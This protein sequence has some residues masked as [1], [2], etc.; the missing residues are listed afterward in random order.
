VDFVV[1]QGESCT[2][3]DDDKCPAANPASAKCE[4][5]PPKEYEVRPSCTIKFPKC[6]GKC[7]AVI[8]GH[9]KCKEADAK[10]TIL[11]GSACTLEC[12]GSMKSAD[13][14][15]AT[16]ECSAALSGCEITP[17]EITCS[18][19]CFPASAMILQPNGIETSVASL[20]Q[21]DSVV[22]V[23]REW[24]LEDD[25]YLAEFHAGQPR[26]H[27]MHKF[28]EIRHLCQLGTPLRVTAGHLLY[29]TEAKQAHAQPELMPAGKLRPGIH[30]VLA[31]GCDKSQPRERLAP[32]LVLNVTTVWAE[33]LYNPLTASRTAIVDGVATSNLALTSES[34][35]AA[36]TAS[37]LVRRIYEP[38]AWLLVAPVH[39]CAMLGLSTSWL[40]NVY[41][42]EVVTS[43]LEKLG[44][45]VLYAS[46]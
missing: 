18:S 16:C 25:T 9:A 6:K 44:Q 32:S 40:S 19:S 2:W 17:M 30:A 34:I 41:L 12:S 21:G 8:P 14:K 15:T 20:K 7:K 5:E 35:E 27:S 42:Q 10:G 26:Q 38:L 37:P 31:I 3:E 11:E 23:S 1:K 28:I 43:G 33:G 36:F 24:G 45:F 22:G 46:A 29:A 13:P 39:V 4:C